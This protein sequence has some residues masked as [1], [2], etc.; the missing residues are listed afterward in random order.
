MSTV[1]IP[2]RE[3]EALKK[4]AASWRRVL[5]AHRSGGTRASSNAELETIRDWAR[6]ALQKDSEKKGRRLTAG[7]RQALREAERGALKGPFDSAEEF[8]ADLKQ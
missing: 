8:M 7:L 1:T 2:K 6:R 3:Y 5:A 4:D